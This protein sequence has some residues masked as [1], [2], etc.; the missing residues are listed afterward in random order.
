VL[1]VCM[2]MGW[3]VLMVVVVVVRVFRKIEWEKEGRSGGSGVFSY[4]FGSGRV[5]SRDKPAFSVVAEINVYLWGKFS[6]SACYT[7]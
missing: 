7:I 3:V 5:S 2:G 4:S 1:R 6:N